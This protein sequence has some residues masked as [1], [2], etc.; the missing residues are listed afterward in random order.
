MYK[1][2][3][4]ESF[5]ENLRKYRKKREYTQTCLAQKAGCHR[6]YI[7]ALENGHINP[8]LDTLVNIAI[9]LEIDPCYL[10]ITTK[11]GNNGN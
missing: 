8:T 10:L 6:T 11:K 3:K 9:E 2:K 5:C 1:T 4:R 7:S